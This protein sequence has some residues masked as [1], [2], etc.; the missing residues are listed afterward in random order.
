MTQTTRTSLQPALLDGIGALYQKHGTS[1]FWYAHF[2][3]RRRGRPAAR[4]TGSVYY[5]EALQQL[6]LLVGEEGTP[7]A[8]A[9]IQERWDE[10]QELIAEGKRQQGPFPEWA[11]LKFR[12]SEWKVSRRTANRQAP[13][14]GCYHSKAWKLAL[15]SDSQPAVPFRFVAEVCL[16]CEKARLGVEEEV[17]VIEPDGTQRFEWRVRGT[18]PWAPHPTWVAA[19]EAGSYE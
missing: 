13:R 14:G 18:T 12:R 16:K 9:L 1:R 19:L 8:Q 17:R 6:V 3:H 7:E 5:G 4:S 2:E 10:L 15:P 11:P